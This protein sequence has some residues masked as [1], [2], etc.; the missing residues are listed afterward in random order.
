MATREYANRGNLEK[1]QSGAKTYK[2]RKVNR[3]SERSR[4]EVKFLFPKRKAVYTDDI[5][6]RP[7]VRGRG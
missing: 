2:L 6:S 3:L 4:D 5:V 1:R 7:L